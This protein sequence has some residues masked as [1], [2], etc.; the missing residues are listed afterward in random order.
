MILG[1]GTDLV[2]VSRFAESIDR[3]GQRF[4]AKVFT[5]KEQDYCNKKGNKH[6][7]FA[8]R[9]AAKEAVIK[10]FGDAGAAP[11]SFKE[12][13]I[14]RSVHGKPFVKLQGRTLGAYR[15][16]GEPALHISISHVKTVA[17]AVAVLEGSRPSNS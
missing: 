5:V 16:F 6:Q 2:E 1:V 17:T 7:C 4:L 14:L 15:K 12:I 10:A 8:A 13:E 9:F 3:F 11:P